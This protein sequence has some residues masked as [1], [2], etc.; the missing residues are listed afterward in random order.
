[1]S[2]VHLLIY[3]GRGCSFELTRMD[4][5]YVQIVNQ[6]TSYLDLVSESLVPPG[7]RMESRPSRVNSLAPRCSMELPDLLLLTLSSAA[8]PSLGFAVEHHLA[9]CLARP[10]F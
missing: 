10:S 9:S 6:F 5:C 7:P 8:G 2:T 4:I 1:M 3:S